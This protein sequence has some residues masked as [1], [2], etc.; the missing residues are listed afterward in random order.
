MKAQA[1]R[2]LR[3]V[4]GWLFMVLGVAGLFLP[5]LQGVLF[6]GIGLAILAPEWPWA[7]R[8]LDRLRHRYPEMARKFDDAKDRAEAWLHR[9]FHRGPE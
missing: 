7:Q 8:Q 6:L 3:L 5:I 4:V 1:K 9:T 2:I